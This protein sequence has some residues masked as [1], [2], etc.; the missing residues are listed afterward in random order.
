M[1][2]CPIQYTQFTPQHIQPSSKPALEFFQFGKG[3]TY[4]LK[5]T[6][7]LDTSKFWTYS[8]GIY[9]AAA[10]PSTVLHDCSLSELESTGGRDGQLPFHI[11]QLATNLG[12][13]LMNHIRQRRIYIPYIH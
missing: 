9:S 8:K 1:K 10:G 7:D 5:T 6:E 12:N 4:F 3:R 13:I 11:R 2:P